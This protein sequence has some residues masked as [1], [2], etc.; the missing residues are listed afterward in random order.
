MDTTDASFSDYTADPIN[1]GYDRVTG[2]V[3]SSIRFDEWGHITEISEEG[4]GGATWILEN[5]GDFELVYN[6][7]YF[8]DVPTI[9]T[10][11]IVT[12]PDSGVTAPSIGNTFII[13]DYKDG[14]ESTTPRYIRVQPHA[15]DGGNLLVAGSA[16]TPMDIDVAGSRVIFTYVDGTYGWRY[17]VI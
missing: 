4:I 1:N 10:N 16:A 9:G 15:N 2:N 11:V 12:L 14:T 8:V 3:I 7:N 6:N 13:D 17:K 5:T